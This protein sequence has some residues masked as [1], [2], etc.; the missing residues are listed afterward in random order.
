M[1]EE[2]TVWKRRGFVLHES[3]GLQLSDGMTFSEGR[4]K[5]QGL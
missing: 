4:R 2:G 3:S 5:E 1:A